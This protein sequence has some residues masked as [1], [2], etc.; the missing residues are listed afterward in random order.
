MAWFR[1]K[2]AEAPRRPTIPTIPLDSY[3]PI[4]HQC[5]TMALEYQTVRDRL[6]EANALLMPEE[7]HAEKMDALQRA[8]ELCKASFVAL[9]HATDVLYA[10]QPTELELTKLHEGVRD[11]AES[12]LE[13]FAYYNDSFLSMYGGKN[14]KRDVI[15]SRSHEVQR[16]RRV[17][18]EMEQILQGEIRTLYQSQRDVFNLLGISDDELYGLDLYDIIDDLKRPQLS[19]LPR[20]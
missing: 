2:K 19:R 7:Q 5:L 13:Y 18:G 14:E 17:A 11:F 6:I 8:D 20:S 1:R 15:Q 4:F 3:A 9:Q 16:W 12:R 10:V